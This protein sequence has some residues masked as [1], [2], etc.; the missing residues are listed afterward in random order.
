[1]RPRHSKDAVFP[2]VPS[3][4]PAITEEYQV[5]APYWFNVGKNQRICMMATSIR[6][7]AMNWEYGSGSPGVRGHVHLRGPRRSVP[8]ISV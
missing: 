1:M 4:C 6:V 7:I 8:D 5:N 3:E 2:A